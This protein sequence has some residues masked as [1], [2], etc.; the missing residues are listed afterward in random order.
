MESKARIWGVRLRTDE[1]KE[2]EEEQQPGI[3]PEEIVDGRW[4]NGD[5]RDDGREDELGSENTVDLADKTPSELVLAG[6]KTRVQG[7]TGL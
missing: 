5:G 4:E 2:H 1:G 7:L 3:S 6:A